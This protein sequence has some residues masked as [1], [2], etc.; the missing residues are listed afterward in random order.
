MWVC[1]PEECAEKVSWPWIP[2]LRG[3]SS[4]TMGFTC[5]YSI[6]YRRYIVWLYLEFYRLA[7]VKHISYLFFNKEKVKLI[8]NNK[9]ET[10]NLKLLLKVLTLLEM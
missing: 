1:L 2:P 5:I 8:L 6:A 9:V 10:I 7:S 3:P 4:L